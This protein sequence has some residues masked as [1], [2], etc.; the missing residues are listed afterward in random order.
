MDNSQ[1]QA[2]HTYTRLMALRPSWHGALILSLHLAPQAVS[3]PFAALAAGA[4]C[5]SIEEDPQLC[6]AAMHAGACDFVVNTV[7]EALRVLKNE[8]RQ[9]KPISVGLESPIESALAELRERRILPELF[10]DS[11]G[12]WDAFGL[13]LSD[14]RTVE[15]FAV[16][17]GWMMQMLA[18]ET[19]VKLRA[20]DAQLLALVHEADIRRPWVAIA[21]RL[22]PRQRMRCVYLTQPEL[23]QLRAA[24]CL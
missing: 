13:T 23:D 7:D 3:V 1:L 14:S 22:F 10:V 2:L 17:N 12:S 8:I 9:R 11:D 19:S 15:A 16:E 21:P 24:G 18:C 6:K 5:L 20:L 4:A